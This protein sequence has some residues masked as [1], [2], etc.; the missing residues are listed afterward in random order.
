MRHPQSVW[1]THRWGL[2]RRSARPPRP[3]HRPGVHRARHTPAPGPAGTGRRAAAGAAR[4]AQAAGGRTGCPGPQLRARGGSSGRRRGGRRAGWHAAGGARR[5]GGSRTAERAA[6]PCGEAR[7]RAA[8]TPFC[9]PVREEEVSGRILRGPTASREGRHRGDRS[10]APPSG[11]A[12]PRAGRARRPGRR[13]RG[14][15]DTSRC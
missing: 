2:A 12:A 10:E 15:R 14:H 7:H 9:H 13:G 6:D 4:A 11:R 8:R 3:G 1:R 5:F